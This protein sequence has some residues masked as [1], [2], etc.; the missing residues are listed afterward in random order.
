MVSKDSKTQPKPDE[1]EV[2]I[3]GPGFGESIAVHFGGGRWGVIDS[4]M[5]R[6]KNRSAALVYFDEIGVIPETQI[7]LI[8]ASHWH[9][10]HIAGIDQ[11]VSESKSAEFWCSESFLRCQ[12]FLALF[13]LSFTRPD[14]KF[15]RG[16]SCISKIVDLIGPSFNFALAGMRI[17]RRSLRI[18]AQTVPVEVWTL[19]PST[20]RKLPR[21]KGICRRT[22]LSGEVLTR[23][24]PTA[25]L[26]IHQLL[27]ILF[28]V[29]REFYLEPI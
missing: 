15:T 9:D 17:Y 18:G 28:W 13:E 2:S 19:C 21:E 22:L 25:I 6:G 24:S 11:I 23:A 10:D 1:I 27:R 20:I 5:N 14:I 16:V 26:I 7:D 3:F 8:V 29:I 12:E 4:C